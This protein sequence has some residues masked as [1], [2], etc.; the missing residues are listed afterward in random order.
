MVK[1][2]V[3]SRFARRHV[4]QQ[5]LGPDTDASPPAELPSRSPRHDSE[6]PANSELSRRHAESRPPSAR[7]GLSQPQ[8]TL[9]RLSVAAPPSEADPLMVVSPS[10]GELSVF[11]GC[12]RPVAAERVGGR[13]PAGRASAVLPGQLP[14][15]SGAVHS[16]DL[17]ARHLGSFNMS[18]NQ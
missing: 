4:A 16:G 13:Q 9:A 3:S 18:T 5:L 8:R 15:A 7:L 6:P 10:D 2:R 17:R 14:G 11:A 1:T 12:G